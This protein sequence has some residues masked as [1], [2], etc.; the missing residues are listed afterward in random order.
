MPF[1]VRTS[2]IVRQPYRIIMIGEKSSLAEVLQPIAAMVKASLYLGPGE[3]TLTRVA[4][5][6]ALAAE[7]SRPAVVLEFVDLDP[8]G[9]QMSISVARK[10][11]ALRTSHYPNLQVQLHRV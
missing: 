4:E 7:D 10:L 6:V 9:H 3:M 11:Q 2:P 8:A 5:A 1:L